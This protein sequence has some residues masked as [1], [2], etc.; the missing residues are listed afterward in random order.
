MTRTNEHLRYPGTASREETQE[1]LAEV[2]PTYIQMEEVCELRKTM[3]SSLETDISAPLYE[4]LRTKIQYE[5]DVL[6][7]H[8]EAETRAANARKKLHMT[9]KT[10]Y[11]VK[12]PLDTDIF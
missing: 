2:H 4:A 5:R 11:F 6:L 1:T 8:I 12:K 3:L 10:E 9:L 7:I